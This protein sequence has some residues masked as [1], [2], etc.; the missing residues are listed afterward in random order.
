M[1]GAEKI[2]RRDDIMGDIAPAA[3]GNQDLGAD[4]LRPVQQFDRQVRVLLGGKNTGRQPGRSG[5]D[6]AEINRWRDHS[7]VS[8]SGHTAG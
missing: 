5:A 3:A 7:F 2:L 1:A 6:D 8:S 4:G